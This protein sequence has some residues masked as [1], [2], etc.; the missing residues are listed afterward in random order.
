MIQ[1]TLI[2]MKPDALKRALVGRILQ[3]FEDVGL[4]IIAS[5]MIWADEERA[6]KHYFDVAQRHGEKVFKINSD[7]LT[8]G[9]VIAFCLEGVNAIAQ[10][11]KMVGKTNPEEAPPGTIR[12]DFCHMTMAYSNGEEKFLSNLVHSSAN[13][14]EAEME[15]KLWFN[16]DELYSYDVVHEAHTQ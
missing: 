5:K 7:Y 9:P 1:R 11:R 4:K 3:R 16:E 2:F 6:K 12:G 10:V 14:E 15:L 13:Q 8:S